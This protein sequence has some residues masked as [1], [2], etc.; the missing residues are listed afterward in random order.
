MRMS[1]DEKERSHQRIVASAARLFRE[2]GLE[3]VSLGDVMTAAGMTHGGFYKHFDSKDALAG[4]AL[5]LAFAE[6]TQPLEEDEGSDAYARYRGRYL[7]PEHMTHPGLGC[8]VAA[9]G[10][11]I[12]RSA[13][14]LKA[15]FGAGIR[16]IITAIARRMKGSERARRKAAIRDFSMLVGAIVIARASDEAAAAEVLAA[17]R[18]GTLDVH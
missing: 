10:Q 7:T 2:R 15:E 4:S 11:D 13:S 16:R 14:A 1:K 12:G 3:G 9:L 8:P 5:A 17:C 6:F 18:D